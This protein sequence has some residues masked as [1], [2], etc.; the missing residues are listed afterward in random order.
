MRDVENSE[1][2]WNV[3]SDGRCYYFVK[4]FSNFEIID[5]RPGVTPRGASR[6]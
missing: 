4:L 6:D 3:T 5:G 1:E 2:C